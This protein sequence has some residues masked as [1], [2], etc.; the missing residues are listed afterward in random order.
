MRAVSQSASC[1]VFQISHSIG[2]GTSIVLEA[3]FG[4]SSP[5]LVHRRHTSLNDDAK[6]HNVMPRTLLPCS[7]IHNPATNTVSVVAICSKGKS[8]VSHAT[9]RVVYF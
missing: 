1:V 2:R 6:V 8:G 7:V 5:A 9:F 3:L 4:E